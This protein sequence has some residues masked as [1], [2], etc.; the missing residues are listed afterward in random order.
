MVTTNLNLRTPYVSSWTL[1][2]Q[3]AITNNVVLEAAYVG[4]HG[5]KFMSHV[6]LNQTDPAGNFWGRPSG[7]AGSPSYA[8]ACIDAPSTDACDGSE[9]QGDIFDARPYNSKFSYLATITQLGNAHWSN[10]NG[11][12][13]SL[14]ARNF[15]GLSAVSGYTWSKSL[16]VA[17]GNGSD[18][19]TDSYNLALDYGRASSDVRHRLTFAPTY[20]FPSVM[21]YG[22]LL[23]GWRVNA[24]VKYQTGRG[25]SAGNEVDS[26]GNGRGDSQR[27]D[28]SGDPGDFKFNRDRVDVAIFHPADGDLGSENPQFGIPGQGATYAA[29]DL[30]PATALCTAGSGPGKL[31]TLEA[32][33]CWTQGTAALTPPGPGNFGNMGRGRLSGPGFFGMDMSLSKRHQITERLTA[34]FR[35]EFFNILNKPAFAQPQIS[36]P[37]DSLGCES[38]CLT[39]GF[40]RVTETPDS[41]AT[42]P[43]LGTGGPRRVQLGVKLIF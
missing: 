16:D 38:D 40:G 24:N 19:G 8:Q 30:A 25:Y 35:A 27:W 14:T 36:Q 1:S 6:D 7:G 18:V 4:N 3:R 13:L 5:T 2:I 37:G 34:E 42:N 32:F 31:A 17:S 41:A 20:T 43:V 11:L 21:G 12:Q 28:L 26:A 33:G 10:Y 29:S 39:A 15:H 23:E 9:L 22:G